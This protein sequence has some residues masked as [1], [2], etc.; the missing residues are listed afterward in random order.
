MLGPEGVARAVT[1]RLKSNLPPTIVRLREKYAVDARALPAPDPDNIH[2]NEEDVIDIGSFPAMMVTIRDTGGRTAPVKN[3][4]VEGRYTEYHFRYR[5]RLYFYVS[6]TDYGP[7]AVLRFR[8]IEAIRE[9]LFR[10]LSLYATSSEAVN[11]DEL[12]WAEE[13]EG[14][15]GSLEGAAQLIGSGAI[16]FEVTTTERLEAL[17]DAEAVTVTHEIVRVEATEPILHPSMTE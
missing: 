17:G 14:G 5:V 16:T 10:N 8:Y 13:L 2:P 7:T 12:T 11:I 3:S 6:A 15:I 1:A 4:D 9:T